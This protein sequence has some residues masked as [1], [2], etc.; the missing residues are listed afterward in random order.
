MSNRMIRNLFSSAIMEANEAGELLGR[1]IPVTFDNVE[2]EYTAEQIMSQTNIITH[3]IPGR[4]I[5]NSLGGDLITYIGIY[6]MTIRVKA[7]ETTAD[8]DDIVDSLMRVFK[9]DKV[10]EEKDA[11]DN[12][13]FSVQVVNPIAAAEGR[14]VDDWWYVPCSFEYRADTK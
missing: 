7:G 10:F 11:D 2:P 13:I 12:V 1:K 8:A 9:V 5:A 6:Q 4:P 3:L 14:R